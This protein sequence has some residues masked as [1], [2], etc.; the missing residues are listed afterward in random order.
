[1]SDRHR[2]PGMAPTPGPAPPPPAL[3]VRPRVGPFPGQ[4]PGR[5]G[6]FVPVGREWERD[7]APGQGGGGGAGPFCA[8]CPYMGIAWGRAA[9]SC[10][11][12]PPGFPGRGRG[13]GGSIP[14]APDAAGG[15][16]RP[17]SPPASGSIGK[18]D[19]ARERNPTRCRGGGVCVS[20]VPGWGG[21]QVMGSPRCGVPGMQAVGFRQ[22]GVCGCS[23]PPDGRSGGGGW[24]R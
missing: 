23:I 2:A 3:P 12:G 15:G 20:D 4:S 10:G 5:A 13:G 22:R 9:H 17:P 24:S 11:V 14:A 21:G 6:P 8:I 1:M 19:P 7:R 16:R 18:P